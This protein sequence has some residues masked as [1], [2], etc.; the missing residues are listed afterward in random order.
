[1]L[2]IHIRYGH[3]VTAI[4]TLHSELLKRATDADLRVLIALCTS[5]VPTEGTDLDAL[6]AAIAAHTGY[7]MTA[8]AASLAFWR[9]AGI[10]SLDESNAL[11]R[12]TEVKTQ[13][14]PQSTETA[15]LMVP[16]AAVPPATQTASAPEAM[17][18]GGNVTVCRAA[19]DKLPHYTTAELADLM[20]TRAEIRE[21]LNE[22]NRIWGKIL[23]VQEVNTLLG[24]SDYLG[25]D[26]DYILSLV[27]RCAA[28]LDKQGVAHSMR[29]VEKRAMDY[30]DAG[31]R[32]LDALQEKFR[33]MDLVAD[34][35]GR[36]RS[37]F[38][39]GDR[40]LTPTETKYF[41]TWLYDFRYDM[42]II[43]MAY[44][45]TVDTKG[46][47]KMS[48]INSILSNWN[49]DQLRTPTEIEASLAA[50]KQEQE[51]DR[52]AKTAK[53]S[54]PQASSAPASFNTD[55]FFDAAV[56]RSLGDDFNPTV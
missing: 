30:Y 40:R 12:K 2:H 19:T 49:R 45:I 5:G 53:K 41:S 38:G 27:A 15:S 56:R 10:I 37:L 13:P 55:D 26:W 6:V 11:T 7:G 4:P 23:N 1:M 14:T 34:T 46:S 29:M 28:D 51:R 21:N 48:Y 50:Y 36:L 24:L 42:E 47:P 20:E 3:A 52:A 25:L 32:T 16:D 39:M 54:P 35:E 33:S 44:N 43:Q 9:G 18:P 22:C 8:I 31:I 17:L